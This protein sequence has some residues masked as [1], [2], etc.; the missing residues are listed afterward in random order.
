MTI[1]ETVRMYF[2]SV[3]TYNL[4]SLSAGSSSMFSVELYECFK[5]LIYKGDY[6]GF[7]CK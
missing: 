7:R 6:N 5:Y 4:R 3:L 2:V 1:G